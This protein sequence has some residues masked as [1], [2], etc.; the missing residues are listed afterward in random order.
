M[1]KKKKKAHPFQSSDQLEMRQGWRT[2][3]A[4]FAKLHKIFRFTIDACATKENALL[5]R[6]WTKE[7]DAALQDWRDERAFCNPPFARAIVERI[8]P[9][10]PEAEL[11]VMVLKLNS[12]TTRYF[13]KTPST[14][15]LLPPRR[16]EFLPP[17][18]LKRKKGNLAFGTCLLVWG[19]IT[20]KQRKQL[21]QDW[22]IF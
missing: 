14:Y 22:L 7:M 2:D 10:A 18:G 20:K 11:T 1:D 15:L 4:I 5:P 6:Y 12:L 3:P 16:L 21:E 8:M 9:R 13:H 17:P 19:R